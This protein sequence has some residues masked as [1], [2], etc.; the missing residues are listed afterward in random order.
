MGGGLGPMA[1]QKR[2]PTAPLP[3]C[4]VGLSYMCACAPPALQDP[5]A[6]G[7]SVMSMIGKGV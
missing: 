7:D 1:T 2:F 4:H 5:E 6:Y 3:P